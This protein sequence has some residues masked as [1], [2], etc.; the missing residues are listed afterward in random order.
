MVSVESSIRSLDTN[1]IVMNSPKNVN[2]IP[3]NISLYGNVYV[4]KNKK[5]GTEVGNACGQG[6]GESHVI[7]FAQIAKLG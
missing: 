5:K 1:T 2:V 3:S 4:R 7:N 6:S